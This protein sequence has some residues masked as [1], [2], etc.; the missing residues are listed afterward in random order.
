MIGFL[1]Q[2]GK[3]LIGVGQF[4]KRK[5]FDYKVETKYVDLQYIEKSGLNKKLENVG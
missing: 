1:Y 5:S 2:V 3:D 4:V